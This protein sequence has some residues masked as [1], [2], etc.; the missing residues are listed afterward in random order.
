MLY[1]ILLFLLGAASLAL[2]L[3][4]RDLTQLLRNPLRDITQS[5]GFPSKREAEHAAP[6]S[7]H[8]PTGR[9]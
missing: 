1:G 2:S 5:V 6:R 3:F 4:G 7:G 9:P 8:G